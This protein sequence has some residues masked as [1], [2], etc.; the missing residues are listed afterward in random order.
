MS[1]LDS[2]R[3]FLVSDTH[4]GHSN[5]IK[6]C[7]R[8]FANVAEMNETMISNW[9]SV[10]QHDD[11]VY[12][13]GDFGIGSPEYLH[14]V[15]QRLK[16][17]IHLIKGNHDKNLL[18][19]PVVGRFIWVKDVH[20]L[21]IQERGK[22]FEIFLSHYAHRTWPKSNRG[23]WHCFGHSHSNLPPHGL[24]FDVGVDCWGFTPVSLAQ[25]EAKMAD[26]KMVFDRQI[27]PKES[28][29]SCR[30]NLTEDK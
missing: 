29:E 17:K 6:Y 23:S 5:V 19:S 15:M 8:P 11:H 28:A 14:R 16:G 25:I 18:K 13:L 10:I 4:F 7:N 26:L 30:Y 3:N 21:K 22:K 2:M 1:I 27:I 9:N 24:S 12:F 20:F